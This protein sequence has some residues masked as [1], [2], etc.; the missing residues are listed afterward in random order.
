M[1]PPRWFLLVYAAS[2]A[3]AL[4]YEV[5]WTRL[6]TL[7]LGHGVAAASTVLA[8]F[9]G[10]L[11]IGAA[12]GGP[13]ADRTARPALLGLY[14]RLEL[15]IAALALLVP[16]AVATATPLLKWA[17]ADGAA[18]LLFPLLRLAVSLL[19]V[20]VPAVAM[21]ATF[22]VIAR[23]YVDDAASATRGAGA[24]YAANT[25][26]AAMGALVTGFVLLPTLGLRAATWIGVATNLAVAAAAWSLARRQAPLAAATAVPPGPSDPRRRQGRRST[27]EPAT[28]PGFGLVWT[29]ALALG[30]SGFASL[31]LQVV[32]S[33][34]LAQIIGPTTYAFSLVV[35]I[36]IAG[37]ALG[38]IVG[39]SVAD[40]SAQPAAWLV[41][42]ITAAV[43][44]TAA[45]A[46][47]VDGGL[48]A[49]A[50]AVAAPDAAFSGILRRQVLLAAGWLLPVALGFGAAFPFAVRLGTART[51]SLGA[52]L[53]LI[54]AVNTVGAI[55]GSLAA[56]FVLV[57]RLGLYDT[58]RAVGVAAA[59]AVLLLGWRAGMRGTARVV[60]TGLGA[61]AMAAAALVPPWDAA[62]ISSG[63]YKYAVGM[64]PE[65]LGISLSAGRLLYYRDG[66]TATVAVRDAAGTT[67]LSIDG[68]VDASNSGDMLTQ[69]LLA[70]VPLLLHPAPRRA[71]IL[72]LGSGVTTGAAL[73]HPVERVDVL[74]ISPEVVEASRF[75]EPEN[76]R[77]L[78]D[79][80]TR[81]VVGDGRTHLL[82]GGDVYDV[83]VSE[84]S[85]PWMAGIASLFT[86]EF[87]AAAKA[88]LAP[89]GVLCQ[90]AHTYDISPDDLRAIVA[91][92]ASVFPDGTL[93]LVGEGDLLLIGGTEPMLPRVAALGDVWAT[94]P[95]AVGDLAR[96]GARD[97]FSLVS[98]LIA[99]GDTLTG[100]A[101]GATRLTDDY[102]R[103][104][105]TGPR[106]VFS[107]TR[108]DNAAALRALA[109]EHP[110]PL[111]EAARQAAS[112]GSW[113]D[114][115]WMLLD[116][117]APQAAW[118]DFERSLRLDPTDARALDGLV[119]AGAAGRAPETVALLRELAAPPDRLAAQVALAHFLASSGAIQDAV[120]VAFAAAERN[121]SDVRALEQLASILSDVGDRDRLRAVV[122]RLRTIAPTA[123][124]SRYYSASLFFMEGRTDQ[125]IAEAR[126][127]VAANPTHARGHNLLGAAL[128]TQGRREAARD[129]FLASLKVEPRDPSTYTN[130]GLLELETGNRQAG[131]QRLAEALLL[132]PTAT[133]AREAY[134]RE[135]GRGEGT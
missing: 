81:L 52:D 28:R 55:A 1:A 101:A 108:V 14:A 80:R 20:A 71:A 93:W 24:L 17:Y 9:M 96:V 40:R 43:L 57:P 53:G 128:A 75:F 50:R 98:L 107:R 72:G 48:L 38:A 3:A 126:A 91:T 11:A 124:A 23:W 42:V 61:A 5:A 58:M 56:G 59:A 133:A 34:L 60:A 76:A 30:V 132:D 130:L 36:F 66:A 129:A 84:P 33:R 117:S 62:M 65:A 90:W 123:D 27:P 122:A 35:A 116:A 21:G 102:A 88:R 63:A 41:G 15:A 68:K 85:N 97:P 121:P 78:A 95:E 115:G 10:G 18:S 19:V 29:A 8:A 54:Y 112:A 32:W 47:T 111:V 125:A 106:T 118:G 100:Y 104:E 127:L 110:L 25:V 39:R 83:I 64:S 51:A 45:A 6:L 74:E 99:A 44:A 73:R 82:L 109:A 7:Y 4:V 87:F 46:W 22:P 31:V 94:R 119:R 92:F 37:L 86:R 105:F 67:S 13:L 120:A 69:R 89:G 113:R 70:H 26:G 2:G 134:A 12:W 131:L 135:R 79:P 114:R 16:V 49:M 77:A 103:V